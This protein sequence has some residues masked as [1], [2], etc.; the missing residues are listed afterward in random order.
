MKNLKILLIALFVNS[1]VFIR[2]DDSID[3]GN[4][5]RY[6]QDYPQCIIYHENDKY[7]GVGKV[8]IPA[9]ILSY[10][11]DERYIIAKS[12]KVHELTGQMT[13]SLIYYWIIDKTTEGIPVES[14]DSIKFYNKIKELNIDLARESD[15]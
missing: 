6:I 11:F 1:C 13:D 12:Y 2:M 4:N 5:Y 10:K 9:E 15:W 3:L 7:E 14:M 8:I